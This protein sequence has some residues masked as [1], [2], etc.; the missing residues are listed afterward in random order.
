MGLKEFKPDEPDYVSKDKAFFSMTGVHLDD[1]NPYIQAQVGS[2]IR[3]IEVNKTRKSRFGAGAEGTVEA[4]NV[5][6]HNNQRQ[7]FLTVV[8]D[9]G[10][11]GKV[12]ETQDI[13]ELI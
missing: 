4:K 6:T 2:R 1:I 12:V 13:I 7:H 11:K 5:Y 8:F 3:V 10:V 9:S